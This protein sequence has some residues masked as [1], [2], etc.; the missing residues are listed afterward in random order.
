M[1]RD[2][3]PELLLDAEGV[4]KSFTGVRA[5][6][7]GRL[8]LRP[9][10]VHALCGGNGAGKS[11]FLNVLMGLI[12]RDGGRITLRGRAM[13]FATPAQAFAASST[14]PASTCAPASCWTGCGSA[15][16]RRP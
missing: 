2:A 15:S 3:T 10:T 12:P 8:A 5:L 16:T 14:A 7:D 4:T 9:G 11:T 6:G 1:T 13:T